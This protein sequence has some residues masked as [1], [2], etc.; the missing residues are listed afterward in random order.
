MQIIVCDVK[1]TFVISNS[2]NN[3]TPTFLKKR[4]G[5][6]IMCLRLSQR[7]ALPPT[8]G[9]KGMHYHTQLEICFVKTNTDS[10]DCYI[11]YN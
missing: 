9:I 1:R 3:L 4:H 5:F 6:F 7:A 10:H 11:P 2:Q 8:A